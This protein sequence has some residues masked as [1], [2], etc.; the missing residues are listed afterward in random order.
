[1]REMKVVKSF[2]NAGD[3]RY[4]LPDSVCCNTERDILKAIESADGVP[5]HLVFGSQLGLGVYLEIGSGINQL[6]GIAPEDLDEKCY[7]DMI[8][9]IIPL[10]DYVPSDPVLSRQMFIN[11]DIK[12]YKAEVLVRTANGEKK[13]LR[14]SSTPVIDRETGKVTGSFGILFDITEKK[15]AA[16][17]CAGNSEPA[18]MEERLQSAFLHNL[19]HEIRTPLNAIVGFSTL[20]GDPGYEEESKQEFLEMLTRSTD[21]FLNIINNIIEIS[22]IEA[23][24]IRVVKKE[25]N[26]NV[27]V[28]TVYDRIRTKVDENKVSLSIRIPSY[29]EGV[30]IVTDESKVTEVLIHLLNNAI[31]FTD[32]GSI[33]FGYRYH[34]GKIE[35]FV[36]DT[37]IGIDQ[38]YQAKIFKRFFQADNKS[39]RKYEGPG[40]GLSIAKAYLTMLGGN[41]WFSSRP[42][43]G[44][45]FYFNIPYEKHQNKTIQL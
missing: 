19:S 29:A 27:L 43:E 40:L 30:L 45:V 33:E 28:R 11:G 15:L 36:A 9:E 16:Q 21:H 41:I 42:G 12:E 17:R 3:H 8:E 4:D 39:T 24:D 37:G 13:W 5:F 35:F 38:E 20:L 44:S 10:S 7:L 14:D 22:R 32:R 6:L 34:E 18:G 1:M 2:G 25:T 23:D 31:K 26:L